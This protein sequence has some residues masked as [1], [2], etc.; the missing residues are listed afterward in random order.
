[1]KISFL[2]IVYNTDF[3]LRHV[4][5]SIYPYAHY[6]SIVQGPVKYW[7]DNKPSRSEEKTR[8]I[9]A[10]YNDIEKKMDVIHGA[11]KEKTE[12]CQTGF[13]IVPEDTDYLWCIDSDEV[14]KAT[15]IEQ[16]IKVLKE[17]N[18]SSVGFRSNTFFGGFDH[19]ITGFER[20]HSFKRILRYEKGCKYMSHRPPTLDSETTHSIM[21]S[22][23]YMKYGVE[24]Y[25]YSYVS[26]LQVKDKIKYYEDAVITPGQ[27]I[28]NYFNKVWLAWVLGDSDKRM[29]IEKQ[30]NG[31]HEFHHLYRGPAF[32]E[33]FD[34]KYHPDIIRED[35]HNLQELFCKQ[36]KIARNG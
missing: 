12:M 5:D 14:F 22:E 4:L 28:K 18:P 31:V 17:K 13:D 23:M 25:H 26:P 7:Q 8:R 16:A 30:Y 6:I 2:M 9:L 11:F 10:N 21:G 3:V 29:K 27:C 36:L 20:A 33:K 32:T 15:H 1:M 24:M 35:M 19:V 34:K